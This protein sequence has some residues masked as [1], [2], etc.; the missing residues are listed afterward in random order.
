MVS[1][2]ERRVFARLST[3]STRLTSCGTNEHG[4]PGIAPRVS[5]ET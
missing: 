1:Q 5:R 4:G 3:R 2:F